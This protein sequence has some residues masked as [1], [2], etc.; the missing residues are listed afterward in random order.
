MLTGKLLSAYYVACYL[1]G[2]S[3]P[4]LAVGVLAD[5]IGLTLALLVLAITSALAALWV[6]TVGI[7]ALDALRPREPI[8]VS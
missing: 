7:R 4:L 5:L 6:G 3:L 8:R 1:G 2:F